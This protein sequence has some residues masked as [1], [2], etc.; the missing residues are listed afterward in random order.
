MQKIKLDLPP[1]NQVR[2]LRDGRESTWPLP[3]LIGDEK[4]LRQVL[5]NL[6]KNA[7]KF[8]RNNGKVKIVPH[9]DPFAEM[10]TVD[11]SDTGVG[12]A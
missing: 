10:L 7:L 9:Y 6:T 12:I 4:R 1:K 8:T 11:V 3:H 5:I 2:S